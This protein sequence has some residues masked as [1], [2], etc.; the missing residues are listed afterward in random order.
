MAGKRYDWTHVTLVVGIVLLLWGLQLRAV[1]SYV[2][3]PDATA[4]LSRWFG[5]PENSAQGRLQRIVVDTASPQKVFTPA[6][7]FGWAV[8]SIGGVL[9]CHGILAHWRK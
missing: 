5:P 7:W 9:T 2:C 8:L 4:L 6:P 1:E 3:T